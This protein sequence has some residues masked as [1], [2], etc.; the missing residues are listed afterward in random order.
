LTGIFDKENISRF[1]SYAYEPKD[2]T[3][4]N[5]QVFAGSERPTLKPLLNPST[6]LGAGPS[7]LLRPSSTSGSLQWLLP[8]GLFVAWTWGL[9]AGFAPASFILG[10]D[11]AV[12]HRFELLFLA[13]RQ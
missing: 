1:Q 9:S 3:A 5:N 13:F 10:V 11:W 4:I 8:Y 2:K 6:Q 12:R 7:T